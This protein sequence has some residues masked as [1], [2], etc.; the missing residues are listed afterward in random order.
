[1]RTFLRMLDYET[2]LAQVACT[3]ETEEENWILI[4]VFA[5]FDEHNAL[6][7]HPILLCYALLSLKSIAIHFYLFI[8]ENC[9]IR[10]MAIHFL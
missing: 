10:I 6:R 7:T 8:P 4:Y 3:R 2:H 5:V 1:M 9:V